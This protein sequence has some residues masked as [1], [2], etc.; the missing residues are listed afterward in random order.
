[1]CKNFISK[2]APK[3]LWDSRKNSNFAVQKYA[4]IVKVIQID[5]H[6]EIL[7]LNNDCVIVPG[8]GGFMAHHVCARYCPD[9][10]TF[11]PPLRQL[12]FNAQLKINDSLL[13]QSYIEAYDIS[14]P[15]AVRCIENEVNELHQQLQNNGYCEL[16]D[17][18]TLRLNIEGN[19][20]F[21]PCEAGILTPDLYGLNSVDVTMLNEQSATAASAKQQVTEQEQ[22]RESSHSIDIFNEQPKPSPQLAAAERNADANNEKPTVAATQKTPRTIQIRVSTLQRTAAIAAAIL[23]F[24]LCSL[25]LG[26]L[27]QPEL[28]KSY[29]DTGIL[30]KLLPENLCSPNADT[31]QRIVTFNTKPV[32]VEENIEATD[33]A[34]AD[35]TD[36]PL[37]TEAEATDTPEAKS[38][39]T[40]SE[41]KTDAKAEPKAEPK[42]EAKTDTKNK[43]AAN[44]ATGFHSIV[45]ASRVTRTNAEEYVARLKKEGFSAAEVVQRPNGVKVIYGHYRS[46][47]EARKHLN[48]LRDRSDVF[49]EA[50]VMK[51]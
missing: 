36:S 45:L 41:A 9:T 19:L 30:Y 42:N 25:P 51:F 5:R 10:Q 40:G 8:L 20:E 21:E 38:V 34:I 28:T 12:G 11:I 23:L 13:A 37:I 32:A 24:C 26:K 1:M 17:I 43:P 14:Y 4:L 47:E 33:A 35:D 6:I 15:E 29:I 18:G 50:W 46:E 44:A 3:Y 16:N 22:T 2:I 7:L 39:T 27:S 49:T 48:S 31:S